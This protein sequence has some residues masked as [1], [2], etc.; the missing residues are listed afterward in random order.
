VRFAWGAGAQDLYH[1]ISSLENMQKALSKRLREPKSAIQGG[2]HPAPP[3]PTPPHPTPPHSQIHSP[4]V[5]IPLCM[6]CAPP[7]PA[8]SFPRWCL[9]ARR[10]CGPDEDGA[11]EPG[12]EGAG[13]AV[14]GAVGP[15]HG[16]GE[17]PLSLPGDGRMWQSMRGCGAQSTGR[18]ERLRAPSSHC[19]DHSPRLLTAD[20]LSLVNCEI[21]VGMCRAGGP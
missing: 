15:V 19:C 1:E 9:A 17:S 5:S 13:K 2:P 11:E 14:G 18:G 8:P 3:H 7:H 10:H 20:E 12:E 6:A 4:L 16:Q 21:S